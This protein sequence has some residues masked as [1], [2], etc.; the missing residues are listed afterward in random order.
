[1]A[2]ERVARGHAR[3]LHRVVLVVEAP[4]GIEVREQ[5]VAARTRASRE[6]LSRHRRTGRMARHDGCRCGWRRL[7]IFL[8]AKAVYKCRGRQ[9][10]EALELERHRAKEPPRVDA[11]RELELRQ[12]PIP[13]PQTLAY[14]V[15]VGH[16]QVG[17]GVVDADPITRGHR[18]VR[19]QGQD[20]RR[21]KATAYDAI[22]LQATTRQARRIDLLRAQLL[23]RVAE[24]GAESVALPYAARDRLPA[25]AKKRDDERQAACA[26]V[27]LR[28]QRGR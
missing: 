15:V 23:D 19:E 25:I 4:G 9:R 26:H 10:K 8:G 21:E 24:R 16:E 5:I 12:R 22:E 11:D 14:E 2:R 7:E 3:V 6:R 27:C 13:R 18:A 17:V 1:M 28:A 20:P